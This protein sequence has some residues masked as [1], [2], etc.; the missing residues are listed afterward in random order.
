MITFEE[1]SEGSGAQFGPRGAHRIVDGQNAA[2]GVIPAK[3]LARTGAQR[4]SQRM[5]ALGICQ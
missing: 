4:S 5:P 2:N 3:T 1:L